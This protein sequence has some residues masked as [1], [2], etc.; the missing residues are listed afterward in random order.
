MFAIHVHQS[1][2]GSALGQ[3][4]A[5]AKVRRMSK[6]RLKKYLE[7]QLRQAWTAALSDERRLHSEKEV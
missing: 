1:D 6:R 7:K 4:R 5:S 2:F 3:S